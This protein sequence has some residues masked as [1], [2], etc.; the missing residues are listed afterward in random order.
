MKVHFTITF[1][2]KPI[3]I[4]FQFENENL[5]HSVNMT[6]RTS[7]METW[8]DRIYNDKLKLRQTINLITRF[9]ETRLVPPVNN[10]DEEDPFYAGCT[11]LESTVGEVLVHDEVDDETI[12]IY[13]LVLKYLSE[14]SIKGASETKQRIVKISNFNAIA[15]VLGKQE[16]VSNKRA[17][18]KT[19]ETKLLEFFKLY[20]HIQAIEARLGRITVAADQGYMYE[21]NEFGK[22]EKV[23]L[24]QSVRPQRKEAQVFEEQRPDGSTTEYIYKGE[25]NKKKGTKEG[26][27]VLVWPEGVQFS[28]SLF[29]NKLNGY[30]RLIHR[31]GDVY[32]GDF[33][34]GKAYG[35]GVYHH[36]NGIKY[37]GEFV[38][39]LPHGLGTEEWPDGSYYEGNWERGN[40]N[41]LGKFAWNN[42][43]VYEG[44]FANGLMHG[45][46]KF[47]WTDGRQYSGDFNA[48][49]LY[50]KGTF[51]WPDG[52][53]Y[54]G[55]YVNNEKQGYGELYWPDGKVYK[56]KWE[57]GVMHGEGFYTSPN[58]ETK[59]GLWKNGERQK[60]YKDN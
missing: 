59:R 55:N 9:E 15:Q 47:M 31:L 38:D 52:R 51:L 18:E 36:S 35:P 56:G 41:E 34:N 11:L 33:Y 45:K 48:G 54:D 49:K 26:K 13:E 8:I 1:G 50:G 27:G 28:G 58:G 22:V 25:W 23:P 53:K 42:G 16:E 5:K 17:A 44:H 14:T 37:S 20:P 10:D 2:T 12:S 3:G 4:K 7:Q 29:D 21:K 43:S 6:L 60:W 57:K 46:G 19:T 30:G 40:K 39:D 32:E 24:D